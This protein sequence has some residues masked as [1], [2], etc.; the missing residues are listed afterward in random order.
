MNLKN[1]G[2]E[3]DMLRYVCY[4]VMIMVMIM[5][6]EMFI[7]SFPFWLRVSLASSQRWEEEEE[8]Q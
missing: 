7:P 1:R 2:S 5:V 8:I 3:R 4:T 6:M